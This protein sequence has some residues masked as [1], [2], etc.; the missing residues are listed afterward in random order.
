MRG[1]QEGNAGAANQNRPAET[2]SDAKAK[3][4][5]VHGLEGREE[6]IRASRA[7]GSN[8]NTRDSG[9][10]GVESLSVQF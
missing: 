3:R 10:K 1:A 9:Q 8:E 6:K 7:R 2:T 4:L 5:R